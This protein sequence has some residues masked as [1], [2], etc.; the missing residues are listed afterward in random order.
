MTM[1]STVGY[2]SVPRMR[3]LRTAKHTRRAP[4]NMVLTET[5]AA[6]AVNKVLPEL[7]DRLTANAIRVP[8]PNVSIID[9]KFVPTKKVSVND[10]NDAIKEAS[11]GKLNGILGTNEIPLVSADFNHNPHSSIFDL[12]ETQVIDAQFVRVMSWYDNEWGFSNR[13]VD[14]AK[15]MGQL[16]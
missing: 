3:R 11:V 13:M 9:F 8:T 12:Q 10:V 4:L 5:G 6:E 1:W 2:L 14:T 7:R 16:I 15:A